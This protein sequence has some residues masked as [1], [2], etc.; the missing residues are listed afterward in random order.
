MIDMYLEK[1][2]GKIN[3]QWVRAHTGNQDAHSKNNKMA[4]ELA[5]EGADKSMQQYKKFIN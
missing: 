4:D 1:Y 3:I 2:K 5:N